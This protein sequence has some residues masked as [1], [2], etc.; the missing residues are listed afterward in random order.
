MIF[1]MIYL[2][3]VIMWTLLNGFKNAQLYLTIKLL[4]CIQKYSNVHERLLMSKYE[5]FKY[6]RFSEVAYV[7]Y[8]SIIW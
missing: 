6:E 1:N 5:A 2:W 4:K 7:Y 8:L 3:Y